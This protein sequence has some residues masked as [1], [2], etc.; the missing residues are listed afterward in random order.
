MESRRDRLPLVATVPN[1]LV[2]SSF[3]IIRGDAGSNKLARS[4]QDRI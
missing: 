2:E 1:L 3:M 4:L